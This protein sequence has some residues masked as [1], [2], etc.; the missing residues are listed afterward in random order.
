MCLLGRQIADDIHMDSLRLLVPDI[1]ADGER[2]LVGT[3][4]LGNGNSIGA[5]LLH[6]LW[7]LQ[8][9]PVVE[10]GGE[11]MVEIHWF[12]LT[13]HMLWMY[14]TKSLIVAGTDLPKSRLLHTVSLQPF[15]EHKQSVIPL[16]KGVTQIGTGTCSVVTIMHF[17]ITEM[18]HEVVLVNHSESENLG[19][20]NRRSCHQDS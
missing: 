3:D 7:Q 4:A 16:S 6:R 20:C 18:H 1:E 15:T 17:T 5:A 11:G 9:Q 14:G 10:F 8:E 2:G 13:P 19:G 12:R